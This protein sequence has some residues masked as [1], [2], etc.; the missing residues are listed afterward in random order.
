MN[1]RI[2]FWKTELL[3]NSDLG[4][5]NVQL[6]PPHK[7]ISVFFNLKGY[8]RLYKSFVMENIEEATGCTC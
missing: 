1:W 8:I 4:P 5:Q 7:Q 3:N 2:P 6:P